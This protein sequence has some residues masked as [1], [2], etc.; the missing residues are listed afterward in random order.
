LTD[1]A[2]TETTYNEHA[3]DTRLFK[4]AKSTVAEHWMHFSD[5]KLLARMTGCMDHSVK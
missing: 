1:R 3:Q 2:I 5:T 4:L